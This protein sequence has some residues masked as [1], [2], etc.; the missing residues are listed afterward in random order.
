M[1]H[2]EGGHVAVGVEVPRLHSLVSTTGGKKVAGALKLK[3]QHSTGVSLSRG[4][5]RRGE[6]SQVQGSRGGRDKQCRQA[7][8]ISDV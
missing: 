6:S 1:T 3:T 7:G 8:R 2:V 4:E 5:A